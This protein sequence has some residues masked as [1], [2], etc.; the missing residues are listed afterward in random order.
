[1][2]VEKRDLAPAVW[3]PSLDY[4]NTDLFAHQCAL[5]STLHA[6]CRK[7]VDVADLPRDWTHV[8][9]DDYSPPDFTD[10]VVLQS[11]PIADCPD[12]RASST[13][14]LIQQ[15]KKAREGHFGAFMLSTDGYPLVLVGAA[16][17][18][19][20]LISC[21]RIPVGVLA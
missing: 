3:M 16:S 18:C 20:C 21:F 15:R 5:S 11:E 7:R 8:D 1:M 19:L 12:V 13:K 14:D 9:L 4:I 17:F 6:C 10:V 2:A